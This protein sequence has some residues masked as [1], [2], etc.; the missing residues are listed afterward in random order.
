MMG[1]RLFV[2]GLVGVLVLYNAE[3]LGQ[4]ACKA[5]PFITGGV[6]PNVLIVFDTSGSMSNILWLDQFD[7]LIDH[8]TPLLSQGKK[9]VF[10]REAENCYL[11]HHRVSY[12]TSQDKI[13][14]RFRNY[15]DP[16]ELCSGSDFQT[17]WSE[18]DH[19]FYFDRV[20]GAFI[21]QT[22]YDP[23]NTDHIRVFLP[24]AT[25]SVDVKDTGQH[26]TWYDYN[27]LNWIFYHS[28]QAQRD[29]IKAMHDDSTTRDI[30][31][32][33][34]AAKRAITEIVKANPDV[35]FGLMRFDQTL[36]GKIAA[37]ISSDNNAVIKAIESP[38][39]WAGGGTPLAETLE[40][41]WDYFRDQQ[42]GPVQQWCQK[43]FVIV[44]TDGQPTW[45]SDNLSG[46][47]KKDW[48]GDSGGAEENRYAGRGSDYL[49]DLAYYMYQNDARPDLQQGS[50]K[51]NVL[52]Y[53]IGF[54]ISNQLLLDTAFNGNGLHGLEAEWSDPGSIHY[55]R[56]YYTASNYQGL[57]AA[58]GKAMR[59]ISMSISSGTASTVVSTSAGTQDLLLRASFHPAGWRGFFDAF[60]LKDG[61]SPP[62]VLRWQA[63]DILMA[64]D[65]ADREIYT[66]LKGLS[67]INAK[68]EFIEDNAAVTDVDGNE[69]FRLLNQS[70]ANKGIDIINFIRGA[71]VKGF[72]DRGGHKL[73]DIVNSTPVV[74]GAPDGF[75]NDPSYI[76][77]RR[78]HASRERMI[79]VGA[80]DG[81]L[82]AFYADDP[83]G[84]EEAWGFIP[85]NLLAKLEHLTAQD[86]E[87]C[88][89]YFVDLTPTVADAFIDPDGTGPQW[90]TTLI[91]G[92]REGGTSFFALDVTDP[93]PGDQST[94]F[95]PLW[96]FSDSRLG[97]SWSIPAVEKITLGGGDKWLAFVGNGFNNQDGEGYL[98]AI[99]MDSGGNFLTIPVGH[100]SPSNPNVLSSARAVDINGDDYADS[101]FSGDLSGRLWRFDITDQGDPRTYS[102]VDPNT[103][104]GQ[105]VFQTEPNQPITQPVGL[106]FYC[107]GPTDQNC[108]NLIT[109]FGT[110]KYLTLA[111][112][113]ALSAQSFYAIK[114]EYGPLTRGDLVDQT[115]NSCPQAPGPVKGWFVDLTMPGERVSSSPLVMGGLVFFLTFVPDVNDQ[116]GAGGTTYLYYR[117]FD[118]GCV[119]N[120][121]VFGEDP[122]PD[123]DAR[124]VGRIPIGPGYASEIFYYAKT[125]EMLIQ[126]SDRTVHSRKVNL[127]R[128]GI[129]NYGWRE[130]F[131]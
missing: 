67:G 17:Q 38:S 39:F 109:Y 37:P 1:R 34:L 117:E 42:N 12:Q 128:G 40:D 53:S 18:D 14:L 97:E 44:I 66:A 102:P 33:M 31:I 78:S 65:P 48:D 62:S 50:E 52:T 22:Q 79:Y 6:S 41:A 70:S 119:P 47:I 108:E 4:G 13:K 96:E 46:Y 24:Y 25:Y 105:Q 58:L 87:S 130:V 76:E 26:A 95:Q 71:D 68:T 28:N 82:H 120:R 73:G 114:D 19:Y 36:G 16:T 30:F 85:N 20:S 29:A 88:H 49:D 23:V 84:G 10:A 100:P 43:N 35:R 60:E 121:T 5:P 51:R 124:P 9:V 123:G 125:Q 57:R 106:S 15:T 27:Y 11:D 101:L 104:T 21:T 8:S 56:Y 86:Y 126:T 122:D 54:T 110:G 61:T 3:A 111:D 112:K 98:F 45:D 116:C 92:E 129:E 64:R 63:A 59:E 74:V 69:L 113:T 94:G 99:D 90:R 77:F 7:P 2:L 80:N 72:R 103:W 118:T 127:L 93:D 91:G 55:Q 83:R 107:S 115:A 75:F 89:E 131:Y 32:R 81:M